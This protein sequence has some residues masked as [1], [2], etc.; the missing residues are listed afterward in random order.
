MWQKQMPPQIICQYKDLREH[1]NKDYVERIHLDQALGNNGDPKQLF[2]Q[3]TRL[4]VFDFNWGGDW[5]KQMPFGGLSYIWSAQTVG[6]CEQLSL[7][8]GFLLTVCTRL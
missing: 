2:F 1:K 3:L 4:S 6:A 7:S 8:A 5:E